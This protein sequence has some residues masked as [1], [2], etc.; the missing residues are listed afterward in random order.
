MSIDVDCTTNRLEDFEEGHYT[1][2]L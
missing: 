1:P 2:N